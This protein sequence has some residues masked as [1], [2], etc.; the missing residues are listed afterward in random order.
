MFAHCNGGEALAHIAYGLSQMVL[1]TPSASDL[2]LGH[3]A[4]KG[5]KNA[6]GERVT[7]VPFQSASALGGA[8]HPLPRARREV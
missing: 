4:A 3:W 8:L 2:P 6:L 1:T 7:V 5:G